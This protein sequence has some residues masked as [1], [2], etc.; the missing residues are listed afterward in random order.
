MAWFKKQ[1]RDPTKQWPDPPRRWVPPE[2]G[3]Y[4]GLGPEGEVVPRP[5]RPPRTAGTEAGLL[6]LRREDR[7]RHAAQPDT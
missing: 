7:E 6:R 4:R 5:S 3:Y 1:V 2:G